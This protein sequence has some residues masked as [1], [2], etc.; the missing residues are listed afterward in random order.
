MKNIQIRN[1]P[2]DVHAVLTERARVAG[3]SLQ[4][5]LLGRL[6]AEA[7]RKTNAEIFARIQRERREHPE[8]FTNV[9]VGEI[10]RKDRESH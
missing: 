9:D 7:A 2:D 5:Y 4:D 10:I 1:V 8:W 6:V 3:Q